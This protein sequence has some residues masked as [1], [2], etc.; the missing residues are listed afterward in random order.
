MLTKTPCGVIM[1]ENKDVVKEEFGMF[2]A[3]ISSIIWG[4]IWGVVVQKVVDNKGYY[5]NWFWW[6]FFFG[7]LALIV[8]LT[9]P[10][11][12]YSRF[13][14]DRFYDKAPRDEKYDIGLIQK[15]G[16]KCNNC[17]RSLPYHTGTCACG[18]SRQDNW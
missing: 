5:E 18:Q 15:G 8:A 3:I 17:G 11:N 12:N 6:G 2:I 7:I 16:W 14:N 1:L 4:I 10:D 13:M 9:K